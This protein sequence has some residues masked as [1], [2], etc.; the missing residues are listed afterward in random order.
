MGDHV[1]GHLGAENSAVP[2]SLCLGQL[3]VTVLFT[4]TTA[5]RSFPG[6]GLEMYNNTSLGVGLLLCLFS[7]IIVVDYDHILLREQQ[8]LIKSV[9]CKC[10][11]S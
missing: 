1:H 9:I 8:I 4:L 3:W 10:S 11:L 2:Y 5:S 7:S 6:E